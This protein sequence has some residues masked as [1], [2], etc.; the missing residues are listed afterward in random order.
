[1]SGDACA[2]VVVIVS[3][4]VV[5]VAAVVVEVMGEVV[6]TVVVEVVVTNVVVFAIVFNR[7]CLGGVA[8]F[9][10]T[11]SV[12]SWFLRQIQNSRFREPPPP[13]HPP[14]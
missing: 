3:V 7:L 4:A 12:G 2:L 1:M 11:V 14:T 10:A 5:M 13:A 9:C 8:R 6:V